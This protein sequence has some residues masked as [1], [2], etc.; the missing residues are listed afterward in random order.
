MD[1]FQQFKESLANIDPVNFSEKYLTLDGKP[2]RL[3]GNGYKPF[4]DIYRYIG[5]TSLERDE[6]K[7]KPVVLVKGRQVGATTMAGALALY[8][9]ASGQFGVGSRPPIR[10]VHAFPTLVHVNRYVKTKLNVMINTSVAVTD[11]KSNKKKPYITTKFEK[12]QTSDSLQFKQ[13]LG[14]G[15]LM[16]ESTGINGDRLRNATVDSIFYDECFPY[17]QE[18]ITD[19]GLLKIGKL[20]ELFQSKSEL[21]LAQSFNED[22]ELFQYKRIVNAWNRGKRRLVQI[23]IEGSNIKCTS[24]HP[25]LTDRGWI[26]AK[27]LQYSDNV[28][29]NNNENVEYCFVDSVKELDEEDFV[30]DIEVEDNHNFII[31]NGDNPGIIVHNC[32]DIPRDAVSNS[33]KILTKSQYGP[34]GTGIQ[35]Y[36]GTPKM[37]GSTYHDIWLNSNQQ[38]YYLGC[39]KCGEYFPLYTPGSDDWHEKIWI[40]GYIVKCTHCGHEQDKLAAADR[41][42]WISTRPLEEC[43]YVGYH[44]N[45]LYNPETTRERILSER[46]GVNPAVTER[47]WQNEVLGEFFAGEAGLISIEEMREKCADLERKLT[48]RILPADGKKVY[49]GFDWGKKNAEDSGLPQGG[50][51]HSTAV[52]LVDEGNLLSV[53]YAT[54]FTKNNFEYKKGGVEEIL[55]K[56]SV[57][58]A[59]GDIGY[60]NDLT[61]IL[62]ESF[63]DRF[64]ASN[65]LPQLNGKAK[66]LA[67]QFPKTIQFEK[68]YYISELVDLMKRGI[69]RF[70]YGDFEKI[71][72][73]LEHCCSMEIKTTFNQYNEP[74][75]RFVKGRTPNDG[76]MALL[77]A[78]LA[79]KFDLTGGFSG[80]NNSNIIRNNSDNRIPA[81]LGYIK[82]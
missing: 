61:E 15:T 22:L 60:A 45:Q 7:V 56:Y 13:F 66:Y 11:E 2:F 47:A 76:F 18:I 44:I 38:Y 21:P 71:S 49:V 33:N 69:I 73:L 40:Y 50:Q 57:T 23:T 43:S 37:K 3:T 26:K 20:F 65:A 35:V 70:P 55:R 51:S 19:K 36:M 41:G 29:V 78:Y 58:R 39:E 48:G 10:M 28:L 14:G 42:K 80:A 75:R 77:N 63:G 81:I 27:D 8:F 30:Y 64:L 17:D 31:R 16:I 25:F 68:D 67:E 62:Q 82:R 6:S 32:Q 34:R 5:L 54:I 59:V 79:Y 53:V 52:V 9:M 12:G 74:V 24:E 46:P 1:L 4:S 72:W